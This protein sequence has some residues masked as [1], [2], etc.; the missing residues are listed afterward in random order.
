[1]LRAPDLIWSFI[2]NHYLLGKERMAFDL[3]FW[4]EDATNMPA[5]CLRS[6]ASCSQPGCCRIRRQ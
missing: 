4:N 2:I 3:L 1:M 6:S 5:A